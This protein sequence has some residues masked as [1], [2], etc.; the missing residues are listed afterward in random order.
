MVGIKLKKDVADKVKSF[1]Y[2]NNMTVSEVLEDIV[3][4]MFSEVIL[5]E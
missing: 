3:S 5:N 4:K 2:E 1:Y